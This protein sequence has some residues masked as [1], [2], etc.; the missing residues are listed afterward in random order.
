M[1]TGIRQLYRESYISIRERSRLNQIRT[2]PVL[3]FRGH[4]KGW[5]KKWLVFGKDKDGQRDSNEKGLSQCCYFN[6]LLSIG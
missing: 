2:V 4:K 5:M 1:K 6:A 3:Q